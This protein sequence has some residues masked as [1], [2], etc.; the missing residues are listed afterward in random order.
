MT[1]PTITRS[2]SDITQLQKLHHQMS[3]DQHI[4]G[5]STQVYAQTGPGKVTKNPNWFH[6]DELSKARHYA[7]GYDGVQQA[8]ARSVGE[9]AAKEI[10]Q[11]V[12]GGRSH[13]GFTK[14]WMPRKSAISKQELKSIL[15]ETYKTLHAQIARGDS[16]DRQRLLDKVCPNGITSRLSLSEALE[17]PEL[18][19]LIGIQFEKERDK[20]KADSHQNKDTHQQPANDSELH[21]Q[22]WIDFRSNNTPSSVAAGNEDSND[23]QLMEDVYGRL[24][25]DLQKTTVVVDKDKTNSGPNVTIENLRQMHRGMKSGEHLRVKKNQ[26]NTVLYS[27][28]RSKPRWYEAIMRF[29]HRDTRRTKFN[30]VKDTIRG[31]LTN[32]FGNPSMA[33][34]LMNRI[35][36]S[37]GGYSK[38]KLGEVLRLA[39]AKTQIDQGLQTLAAQGHLG[40]INSMKGSDLLDAWKN[41]STDTIPMM[42]SNYAK[43]Y[44]PTAKDSA[45][46]FSNLAGG[47][48]TLDKQTS[49]AVGLKSAQ[50]TA[51]LCL[52][53]K[54]GLSPAARSKLNWFIN[55]GGK[56]L[57][58]N[59]AR[60]IM[61]LANELDRCALKLANHA[62]VSFRND[63]KFDQFI[64][65][66]GLD[67][68]L[69]RVTQTELQRDL[70]PGKLA[71]DPNSNV[72]MAFRMYCQS[73]ENWKESRATQ[74]VQF[75]NHILG[76]SNNTSD[77]ISWSQLKSEA[78][79]WLDQELPLDRF[80][81]GSVPSGRTP[82]EVLARIAKD[83]YVTSQEEAFLAESINAA[84]EHDMD[85]FR[86]FALSKFPDDNGQ[87]SDVSEPSD[88]SPN[89][90]DVDNTTPKTH[91][92]VVNVVSTERN[93]I[94]DTDNTPNI[95]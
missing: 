47:L 65:K 89:G 10:M 1:T 20:A 95:V 54:P 63:P 16:Q 34:K 35:A 77:Q 43:I 15:D 79:Y 90:N 50:M 62:L 57:N 5:D 40:N 75:S 55:R 91:P 39:D 88:S 59:D 21:Q 60:L 36:V 84:I 26:N 3:D 12:M 30:N 52:Y 18:K 72:S 83:V 13:R 87:D 44:Q 76:L 93:K 37:S 28:S 38:A 51:L 24:V 92:S 9:S 41:S 45:V 31:A 19:A 42:V 80:Q 71:S 23:Y 8:I 73:R 46:K 58:K 7:Q 2:T 68:A 94:D 85:E 22:Y 6:K 17:D 81:Q 11:K 74:L 53:Y 70:T 32:H 86:Q 82:T 48:R 49:L 29:F 64:G 27:M 78:K 4:S 69:S 67:T 14:C 61:D 33:N 56:P 25:D 66:Q